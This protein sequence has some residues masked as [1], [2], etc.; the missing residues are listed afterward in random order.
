MLE[1]L[2]SYWLSWFVLLSR[3]ADRLNNYVFLV[4]VVLVE[5]ETLALEP[6]YLGF[7]FAQLEEC[8]NNIVAS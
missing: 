7:L 5:G 2:L 8:V 1:A 6:I 3:L 4:V